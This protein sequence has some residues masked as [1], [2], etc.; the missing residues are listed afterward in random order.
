MKNLLMTEN[1]FEGFYASCVVGFQKPD[2]NF[3]Y[4]IQEHLILDPSSIL[5]IDDYKESTDSASSLGWNTHHFCSL[6]DFKEK[7]FNQL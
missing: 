5:F 4:S 2:P 1:V 6:G 3:F 7:I